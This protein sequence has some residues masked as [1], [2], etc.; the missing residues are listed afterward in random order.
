MDDSPAPIAD[1]VDSAHMH[2]S[3]PDFDYCTNGRICFVP[4]QPISE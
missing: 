3:R 1:T 2:T 4:N